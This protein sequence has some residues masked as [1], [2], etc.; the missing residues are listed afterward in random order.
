MLGD[1]LRWGSDRESIL[2][3]VCRVA[4]AV[5]EERKDGARTFHESDVGLARSR[6]SGW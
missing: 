6:E 4:R 2:W 3:M 1:N 5:W